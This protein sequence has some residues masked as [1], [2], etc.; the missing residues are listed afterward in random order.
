MGDFIVT[1]LCSHVNI[2]TLSHLVPRPH[3]LYTR[4]DAQVGGWPR[5]LDI[6]FLLPLFKLSIILDKERMQ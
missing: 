4:P 3:F 6:P 5:M 1:F 2:R